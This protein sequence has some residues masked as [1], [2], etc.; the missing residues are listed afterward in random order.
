MALYGAKADG[1]ANYHFFEPKLDA[2]MKARRSLEVDLRQALG[3][4]DLELHYQPVVSIGHRHI[5]GFEALLRWRHPRRG[6]IPPAEFIPVAEEIGLITSLGEWVLREAC[7]EAAR[8]PAPL[9]VAVN[10]SPVHFTSQNLVE[11]VVASL[12]GAGIP[13]TRLEIEITEAVLLQNTERTLGTMR[14]L[15]ELGVRIVMDDFGTG[16]SSLS[17]LRNFPLNKIK[18]DRTFIKD[19]ARQDSARAIVRAV[20]ALGNSLGMTTTAEGIETEE[21]LAILRSEGCVEMQGHLFSPA[22]PATEIASLFLRPKPTPVT[23]AA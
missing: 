16:Y 18:I 23:S 5:T 12:A 21:Q 19:V 11:S 7:A 17:Y 6:S 9:S 2:Q 15:R 4:G 22:R 10:I 3:N 13:A 1:R 8:W 14:Q 20:V